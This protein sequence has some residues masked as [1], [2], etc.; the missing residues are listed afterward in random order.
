VSL[1]L[2]SFHAFFIVVSIALSLWVG[3]W[4]VAS[5]RSG[6]DAGSLVLAVFFL[7]VGFVLLLY[8][9]RVRRKLKDLGPEE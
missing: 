4:G 3:A 7:V 9:V 5:Y 1:S 2:R 8:F 6:G